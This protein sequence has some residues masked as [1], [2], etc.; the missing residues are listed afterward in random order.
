LVISRN[1][2]ISEEID[3]ELIFVSCYRQIAIGLAKAISILLTKIVVWK[4]FADSLKSE[5]DRQLVAEY[6][7]LTPVVIRSYPKQLSF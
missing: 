7:E 2:I 5:E 6:K 1:C 3:Y 4:G